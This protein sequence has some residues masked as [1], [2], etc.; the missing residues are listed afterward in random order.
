MSVIEEARKVMQDF[1]APELRQSAA[2]LKAVSESERG[3]WRMVSLRW[4]FACFKR[5]KV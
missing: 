3:G 1:L 4:K 2:G 5:S